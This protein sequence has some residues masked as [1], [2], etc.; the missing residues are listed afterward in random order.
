[1]RARTFYVGAAFALIAGAAGCGHVGKAKRG[2]T[3]TQAA[4]MEQFERWL[5]ERPTGALATQMDAVVRVVGPQM[6]CTGTLIAP[7]LVLTA[8]HCVVVRG[9]KREFTKAILPTDKM[10]VELGGDLLPFGIVGLKAIVAPPCGEAGGRGDVAVL[11]L[12]R[13]L[14]GMGTVTPRLEAPPARGE[15]VEPMGFGRCTLSPDGIRRRS[16]AGGPITQLASGTF[17]V[18]AAICPGDS[19][20]P[21]MVRGTAAQAPEVIGVV[22]LSAMDHDEGTKGVSV[23]SRI[24]AFRSVFV[25]ARQIADGADASDMPPLACD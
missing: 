11:V 24:D 19:G 17:E 3:L 12:E 14:V 10:T 16:R 8:H 23:M 22:S 5:I 7:D 6:T 9:P 18:D 4:K 15:N 25:Y 1:V 2:P 21:L 13:K 20:G